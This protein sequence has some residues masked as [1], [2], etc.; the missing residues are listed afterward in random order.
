MK[1]ELNLLHRAG[2]FDNST[3]GFEV[4]DIVE[5]IAV[6]VF[7]KVDGGLLALFPCPEFLQVPKVTQF[8]SL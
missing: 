2:F 1:P 4:R 8:L 6:T 7:W 3:G 5:T